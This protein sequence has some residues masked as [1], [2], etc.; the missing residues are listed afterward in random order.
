MPPPPSIATT[1]G[2]YEDGQ[3]LYNSSPFDSGGF[4]Y[5]TAGDGG[6]SDSAGDGGSDEDGDGKKARVIAAIKEGE[7]IEDWLIGMLAWV[8]QFSPESPIGYRIYEGSMIGKKLKKAVQNPMKG[9]HYLVIAPEEGMGGDVSNIIPVTSFPWL[10]GIDLTLDVGGW[11]SI[12]ESLNVNTNVAGVVP[13]AK[14]KDQGK[15]KSKKDAESGK[16]GDSAKK[17]SVKSA[18]KETVI[19]ILKGVWNYGKELAQ[20]AW[21]QIDRDFYSGEEYNFFNGEQVKVQSPAP[22]T[23]APKTAE[24]SDKKEDEEAVT[25]KAVQAALDWGSCQFMV[26]VSCLGL[27]EISGDNEPARVVKLN[28]PDVRG[29]EGKHGLSGKYTIVDYKHVISPSDGFKTELT[30]ATRGGVGFS[31]HF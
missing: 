27:P 28:M 1:T 19:D 23:A 10:G 11:N 12:V 7:D 14:Q 13:W 29:G 22:G 31:E 8:N 20:A 5:S 21:E 15:L 2:P 16:G 24:V 3:F 30:L 4:M 25:A 6:G 9:K 18:K 17:E 26:K